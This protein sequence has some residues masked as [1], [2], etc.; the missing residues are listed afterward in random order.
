MHA[1]QIPTW[2]HGPWTKQHGR[3]SKHV[4]TAVIVHMQQLRYGLNGDRPV[5]KLTY[6]LPW[7]QQIQSSSLLLLSWL[8]CSL[9]S[10]LPSS[11][12]WLSSSDDASAP[13]SAPP[14]ETNV[15][16]DVAKCY[17]KVG[18]FFE[19]AREAVSTAMFS[20]MTAMKL[21][22]LAWQVLCNLPWGVGLH[23]TNDLL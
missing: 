6:V 3:C 2:C 12:S 8:S 14:A 11:A 10:F 21:K 19:Q 1:T 20:K 17:S 16:Q 23:T 9:L 18:F 15:I 4:T 13:S 7:T 5:H 22:I